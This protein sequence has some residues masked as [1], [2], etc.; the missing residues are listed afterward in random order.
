M[1][2]RCE[3]CHA[4]VKAQLSTRSGIHSIVGALGSPDCRT[5][6]GEH[7]GPRASLNG[8]FDHSR[9]KFKL[10]GRHRSVPCKLCKLSGV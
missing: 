1:A 9:F 3:A 7:H 5:C 8:N 2:D 6:H 10:T 4:D